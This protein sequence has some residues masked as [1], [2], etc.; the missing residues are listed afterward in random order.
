MDKQKKK[1][2]QQRHRE[3]EYSHS[4]HSHHHHHRKRNPRKVAL[5]TVLFILVIVVPIVGALMLWL[6][7]D[8]PIRLVGAYTAVA[9]TVAGTLF[10]VFTARGVGG[11]GKAS[12]FFSRTHHGK[13]WVSTREAK[14]NTYLVGSIQLTIG[15]LV[16]LLTLKFW[17]A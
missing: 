8:L 17:N 5:D 1:Q 7:I 9:Q 6:E 4:H 12:H 15:I 14:G 11:F 3:Y 13:R 16:G 10:L 2:I